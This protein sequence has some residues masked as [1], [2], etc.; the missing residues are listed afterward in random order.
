MLR[1]LMLSI[2]AAGL[3][4]PCLATAQTTGQG[5]PAKASHGDVSVRVVAPI[6]SQLLAMSLPAGFVTA[7][8]HTTGPSYLREA[9]PRGETVDDWS[10]MIT[11]TG[12]QGMARNPDVTPI[13]IAADLGGGFRRACPTSFS[14]VGVESAKVDGN[15]AFVAFLGCGEAGQHDGKPYSESAIVL[16]I[17]GQQD[18]YTIQ[19]AV[20]GPASAEPLA[21]DRAGWLQRLNQLVPVV[22]CQE[23]AGE[24]EPYP[25]CVVRKVVQRF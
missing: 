4:C 24:K 20:R 18:Y 19:W 14:G 2:V 25:S 22:L 12:A 15:D 23:A 17:K 7:D 3:A 10:Q 6:F 5:I 11:V 13:G 21:F 16:V 9:V 1:K 8:E